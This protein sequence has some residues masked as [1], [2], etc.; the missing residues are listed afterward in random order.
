MECYVTPAAVSWIARGN[1]LN[2]LNAWLSRRSNADKESF[3]AYNFNRLIACGYSISYSTVSHVGIPSCFYDA[4]ASLGGELCP[5]DVDD[6]EQ[7]DCHPEA[8][9]LPDMMKTCL[10]RGC[11]WCTQVPVGAP[12]CVTPKQDGYR[13]VGSVTV[14]AKGYQATLARVDSP[15]WY[16]ADIQTVLV[17]VEFHTENRL[18]IKVK[19]I[20]NFSMISSL[21]HQLDFCW[22]T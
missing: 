15:S 1:K 8:A 21:S 14:T 18:R 13:V 22:L 2:H 4:T 7:V 5:T 9:D 17:E 12:M 3:H 20:L 10:A 19:W 11:Y 6:N 16:G